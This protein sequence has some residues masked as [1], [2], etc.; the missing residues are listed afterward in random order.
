MQF[1]NT[2]KRSQMNNTSPIN[3]LVVDD[4]QANIALLT[5]LLE[6]SGYQVCAANNAEQAIKVASHINP[7]LILLDI[8]MPDIDGFEVCRQLK[9]NP[10]T[11]SIPVIFISAK[12]DIEDLMTGFSVGAVDYINKPFHTEEV[13]ARINNQIQIQS[14]NQQLIASEREMR[15]LVIKY[16]YQTERLEQIVKNVVDGI[17]ETTSS[18]I[19]QRV[20]PAIERLFGYKAEEIYL[21]NF[22]E[23]L[24]EPFA[25]QY[26]EILS[27]DRNNPSCKQAT[28]D[29][30]LIELMGKRSN[31]S[32]FPIEF[33]FLKMPSDE[34]LYLIVIRDISIYKDKEEKLRHLSYID[35]LTKLANRRRFDE[36]FLREWMR[37]QRTKKP[38]TFIMIDIDYFKQYNDT[39]GHQAGDICLTT[40]ANVIKNIIKRPCDIIA[41]IGGEEFAVILPD[42]DQIGAVNIAE[43]LRK[44][45]CDLAIPHSSS[46]HKVITISLGIATSVSDE[47]GLTSKILYNKADQA[48]YQ[49]KRSGRNKYIVFD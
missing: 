29:E 17:L 37:S 31:G 2:L 20:N 18:G 45:V 40:L 24:A 34:E 16:Q 6:K 38:L 27:Y 49:A 11:N 14:L 26:S 36:S 15:Q 39:Y 46:E 22:T 30:N 19:I 13:I 7:N 8:M 1:W 28:V 32:L 12:T 4:T 43:K 47:Q 5:E 21:T 3:I 9:E 10:K 23:L 25:S 48:L 44:S 33:S 42:T 41:R 35:P